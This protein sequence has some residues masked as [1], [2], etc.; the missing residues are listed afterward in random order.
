M[1]IKLKDCP[2]CGSESVDLTNN[3][4]SF[5]FHYFQ[6]FC[7]DCGGHGPQSIY[8]NTAYILWNTRGVENGK[9]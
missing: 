9:K 5:G 2:F 7:N 1:I 3:E 6:C 8:E 4:D